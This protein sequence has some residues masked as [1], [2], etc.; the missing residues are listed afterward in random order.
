M[1][2]SLNIHE[3]YFSSKNKAN[4]LMSTT[5]L[6]GIYLVCY[7]VLYTRDIQDTIS[8]ANYWNGKE[9]GSCSPQC[10]RIAVVAQCVLYMI[11]CCYKD[12]IVYHVQ[13]PSN[14]NFTMSIVPSFHH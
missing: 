6:Y 4:K 5:L 12:I 10:S 7:R 1:I 11:D 2:Y 13:I 8:V 14:R 9:V 3:I